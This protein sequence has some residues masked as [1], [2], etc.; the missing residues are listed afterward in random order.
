MT[1]LLASRARQP[2]SLFAP[3]LP[4]QTLD[5]HLAGPST[6]GPLAPADPRA[7]S[8][9]RLTRCQTCVHDLVHT[10]PP[11]LRPRPACPRTR[12]PAA[13]SPVRSMDSPRRAS[14]G[15]SALRADAL[16]SCPQDS[17]GARWSTY[18]LALVETRATL[19]CGRA[20]RRSGLCEPSFLRSWA[21]ADTPP[22]FHTQPRP[23]LSDPPHHTMGAICSTLGRIISVR[24]CGVDHS[25][26][27]RPSATAS[28]PSSCVA[29]AS[30]SQ[31]TVIERY[32]RRPRV[33]CLRHR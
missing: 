32:L 27:G 8:P 28:W 22:V 9:A 31:L 7:V 3:R 16:R 13:S 5:K 19:Q 30:P 18:C 10:V 4:A 12:V 24:R 29:P 23:P 11:L 15:T 1:H 2:K 6:P 21:L 33:H 26:S 14:A 25:Y 17:R 20:A